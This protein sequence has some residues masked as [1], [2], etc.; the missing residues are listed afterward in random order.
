MCNYL[1]KIT[2]F[3][4]LACAANALPQLGIPQ[5][6][7]NVME[8]GSSVLDN[9]MIFIPKPTSSTDKLSKQL[10]SSMNTLI[11]NAAGQTQAIESKI[12]GMSSIV[13]NAIT[14]QTQAIN[15]LKNSTSSII[16]N[17]KQFITNLF[18][19]K[20]HKLMKS[21]SAQIG[22]SSLDINRIASKLDVLQNGQNTTLLNLLGSTENTNKPRFLIF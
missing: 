14:A 7:P 12:T 10:N 1:K 21:M 3:V 6:G 9:G 13:G 19:S 18:E 11:S 8:Q 5:L 20:M 2:V 4:L 17:L 15:A 16:D 22:N